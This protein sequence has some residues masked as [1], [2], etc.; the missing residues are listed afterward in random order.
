MVIKMKNKY[1]RMTKDEKKNCRESFYKTTKGK[2]MKMRF[3]RLTVLGV[4]GILFSAFL[5][6]SGYVSNEINWTT[7]LMA[8]V[9]TIFS[10]I[11]ILGAFF[12][13]RKCFN[14]FAVK[15]MK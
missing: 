12:L 10:I 9:L 7:W 15:K 13:S 3:Q 11:Y 1:Q 8:I 14:D 6:V 2:E 5:V 4:I